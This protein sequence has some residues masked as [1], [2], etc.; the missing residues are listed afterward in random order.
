MAPAGGGAQA[1]ARI[2]IVG[3]NEVNCSTPDSRLGIGT[4]GTNCGMIDNI[5]VGNS[6]WCDATPVNDTN[7]RSF[8]VVF[9]R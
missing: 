4:Q 5:S 2:G 6:A 1:R 3:N 9:V 8:G 7:L